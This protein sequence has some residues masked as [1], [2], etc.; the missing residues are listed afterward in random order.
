MVSGG[1]YLCGHHVLLGHAAVY[2]LYKDKYAHYGGKI[3][4]TLNSRYFY[5]KDGVDQSLTERGMQYMVKL[6]L[7]FD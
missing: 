4:I 7:N 5:P 3:G 1:E 2:H 6:K